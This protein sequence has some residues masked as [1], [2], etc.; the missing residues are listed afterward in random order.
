MHV[1]NDLKENTF[2]DIKDTGAYEWWYFDCIDE[3]NEYSFVAI[4][5]TGN[6]FSPEYSE[7]LK[8]HLKFPDSDKPDPMDFCAISFN[9][10]F[11]DR[12]LYR[13]LYEYENGMFKTEQERGNEKIS[14]ERNNF[15]FDK[16]ENKFYLNLNLPEPD[17]SNNFK[18]EFI[19]TVKS[20][21]ASVK[22]PGTE[23]GS[24]HFWL[25]AANVCEVSGKFKF[26]KNFKRTKTEF[27][28]FG[29]H[30][31]NWGNEAM[32]QNIKDWYWGRVV[33]D[34]YSLV[35]F[36]I[37]YNEEYRKPFKLLYVY[38]D[39][40]LIKEFNEFDINLKRKKNYWFLSFS[41]SLI[42]KTDDIKMV[43]KNKEKMDNGPFYIRFLSRFDLF[44]KDEKVL[45]NETGFSEYIKPSRFKSGFL[46]PFV[47]L[48]I[49][50]ISTLF[51][52]LLH[53]FI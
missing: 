18:S 26:Y 36:Y 49:K 44:I 1:I 52:Y 8:N 10:Y 25:P 27:T 29:Y 22:N 2:H 4:F 51:V 7:Q 15:Y 46:K 23:A 34:N 20:D 43:C 14:I 35:Y 37:I 9:L 45:S 16:N 11:Q 12:V 5:L 30:D 48:R 17:S 24:K 50:K 28:G 13:I 33:T 47:N 3:D 6:P 31:H 42:I 19:F 39:G 38:K 40:K 32:F 53:S 41:K 21:P